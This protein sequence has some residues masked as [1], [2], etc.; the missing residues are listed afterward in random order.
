MPLPIKRRWAWVH[1]SIEMIVPKATS[2]PHWTEAGHCRTATHVWSARL[3]FTDDHGNPMRRSTWSRIWGRIRADAD[4]LLVA[5][6]T[7]VRVPKKC[8]LPGLREFYAT[9]L[10][11]RRENVKLVQVRLGHSKPSI[12]LDR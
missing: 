2:N 8:T 9:T 10:I 6:G 5:S 12:T 11:T 3:L 7:D 4:K 1:M